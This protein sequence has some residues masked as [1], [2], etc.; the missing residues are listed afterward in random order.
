MLSGLSHRP[1]LRPERP[2]STNDHT[3]LT[4]SRHAEIA[5]DLSGCGMNI[6]L[7]LTGLVMTAAAGCSSPNH[8]APT[9]LPPPAPS[10]VKSG[11]DQQVAQAAILNQQ[12]MGPDY[13]ATPFTP[14]SQNAA[15]DAALN[16]CLGRPPTATHE[17]ARAFSP[18]FTRDFQ[19]IHGSITFVDSN[20]TAQAVI[21]ALR[22]TP[23]AVPC[24]QNSLTAK[25]SRSGGSA[26]VEVSRISPPPGGPD[27]DVVA[28][29]LRILAEADGERTPLVVD[30]VSA[31]KGRA[32]MS[33]SFQDVNQPLPA[34]IQ[35]R[36]VRTMLD[37]LA[38]G[39]R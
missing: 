30:M 22:D 1:G 3:P 15:D 4:G 31:L 10:E 6:R 9:P 12:D 26:Q 27:V 13:R 25:L 28:Y 16:G 33:V 39:A 32:E 21:V 20:E 29:R 11:T 38:D 18:I 19:A 35:D 17:R 23:R 36:V 7:L 5:R 8:T 34:D 14:D 2:A 24:L 37:R